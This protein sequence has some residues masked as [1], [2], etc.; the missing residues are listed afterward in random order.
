M[1]HDFRTAYPFYG[2]DLI[3]EY[4]KQY[5]KQYKKQKTIDK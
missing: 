4:L 3:A 1:L 2:K 5:K